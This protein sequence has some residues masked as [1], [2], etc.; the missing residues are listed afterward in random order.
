MKKVLVLVAVLALTLGAFSANAGE[1]TGKFQAGSGFGFNAGQ[2]GNTAFYWNYG[3]DYYFTDMISINPNFFLSLDGGTYFGIA[4]RV[5]FTFDLPVENLEINA[6]AGPG[7][8]VGDMNKFV[9]V[10]GTGVYYYLLDGHLGLGTDLDF[11]FVALSGYV[12]RVLW[13]VASVQ[14]RF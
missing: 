5:R 2:G 3:M 14:Y 1:R 13:S 8:I 9:F 6:N 7:F 11:G 12:F 4:P 10:M